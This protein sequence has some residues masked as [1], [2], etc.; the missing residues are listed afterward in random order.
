MC[1]HKCA[2]CANVP[3]YI[4]YT[5]CVQLFHMEVQV[6]NVI[7]MFCTWSEA[8]ISLW[9]TVNVGCVC[10]YVGGEGVVWGGEREAMT[11]NNKFDTE[12]ET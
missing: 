10:V 12:G 11:G 2:H 3:T 8:H 6:L 4:R 1:V 5:D 7:Q 9:C